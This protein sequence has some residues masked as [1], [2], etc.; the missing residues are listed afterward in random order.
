MTVTRQ[1]SPPNVTA[2]SVEISH[3]DGTAW[4][5]VELTPDGPQWTAKV[6]HPASGCASLRANASDDK[7]NTVS[8]AITRAY[9]IG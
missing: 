3:D 8:Q 7:G 5:P 4:R 6:S 9:Q 1:D 2:L